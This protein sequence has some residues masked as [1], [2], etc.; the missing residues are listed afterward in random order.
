MNESPQKVRI[1]DLAE[2]AVGAC[3]MAIPLAAEYPHSVEELIGVRRELHARVAERWWMPNHLDVSRFRDLDSF[4]DDR[5]G[6]ARVNL[7]RTLLARIRVLRENA[8][9][10]ADVDLQVDVLE[11]TVLAHL[12]NGELDSSQAKLLLALLRGREE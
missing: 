12:E 2:I 7:K 1:R 3:V 9:E 5:I 4:L 11:E 10:Q 8:D 6:D